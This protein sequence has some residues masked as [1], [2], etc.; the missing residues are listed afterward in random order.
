MK[1]ISPLF[2]I[3][4][5]EYHCRYNGIFFDLFTV[6]LKKNMK[7]LLLTLVLIFMSS[8]AQ[9]HNR[10]VLSINGTWK[11]AID[12]TS[13]GMQENWQNGMAFHNSI[14]MTNFITVNFLQN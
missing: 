12:S 9:S 2:N 1:N 10:Q 13:R 14:L 5:Y 8:Y 6:K 4:P 7:S 3:Y 11:F